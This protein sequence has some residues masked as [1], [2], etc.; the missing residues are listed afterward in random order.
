MVLVG[1]EE[2]N[3]PLVLVLV[4]VELLEHPIHLGGAGCD[5]LPTFASSRTRKS[6]DENLPRFLLPVTQLVR[7]EPRKRQTIEGARRVCASIVD[8]GAIREEDCELLALVL[9]DHQS[10]ELLADLAKLLQ[11]DG[12]K[13]LRR[14]CDDGSITSRMFNSEE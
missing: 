5:S 3:L 10:R 6:S 8:C 13:H 12:V 11:G 7:P 2:V 9:A 14:R 1:R 4:V